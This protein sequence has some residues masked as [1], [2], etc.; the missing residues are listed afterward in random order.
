MEALVRAISHLI[1][2]GDPHM[3]IAAH[4][5]KLDRFD[6]VRRRLDP[7]DDFEMW[8]WMSLSGGTAIINAA[9]HSCGLT[10]ENRYFATQ[11]PD[12]YVVVSSDGSWRSVFAQRCD[13]IHIGL[14][15]IT[16]PLPPWIAKAY[17][18]MEVLE[19]HRDPCIRGDRP[20]TPQLIAECDASYLE[21]VDACRRAM[22]KGRDPE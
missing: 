13:L 7:N 20:I 1:N 2:Q 5:S 8:Y 17:A 22:A 11:V 15:E 14:P 3:N 10:D 18:A 21:I 4:L 9:L 12:V 6:A 16:D 19:N